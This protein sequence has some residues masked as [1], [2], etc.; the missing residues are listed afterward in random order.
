MAIFNTPSRACE[1]GI[2]IDDVCKPKP[3]RQQW[4]EV[5]PS[6]QDQL[7]QPTHA[8]LSTGTQGR[9]DAVIANPRGKGVIGDVQF[10]RIDAKTR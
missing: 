1:Q 9:D 6:M 10:A 7:H 3:V 5:D 4:F 2:R 8:F